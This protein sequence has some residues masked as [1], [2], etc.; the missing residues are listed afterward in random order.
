[1]KSVLLCPSSLLKSTVSLYLCV[2]D[3]RIRISNK[4]AFGYSMLCVLLESWVC[5]NVCYMLL[6]RLLPEQTTTKRQLTLFIERNKFPVSTLTL[7]LDVFLFFFLN[8]FGK[9]CFEIC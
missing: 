9:K 1:M 3:V 7:R 8:M 6:F 5:R 2:S 4:L